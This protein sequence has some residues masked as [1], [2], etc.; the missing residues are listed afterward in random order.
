MRLRAAYLLASL[1]LVV[2]PTFSQ[3]QTASQSVLPRLV[4][5]GG[6][7]KDL[8]GNPLAG[9]VGITFALY[10][11]Q[12]GGGALWLET[13]NVI[14]D[15][16]GH[17][18]ALLGSTKPDGLPT[19]LFT[20]EQARW[21]GVQVSGQ[22]EQPRVLLLSVPYALK[23]AD[24]ETLGGKPASAYL[25]NP[26]PTESVPASAQ[27]NPAAAG[28][29][30]ITGKRAISASV[31]GSGTTNFIPRW[32]SS[33][34]LGN[35]VIFQSTTGNLGIGTTSPAATLDIRE[36][37]G[38]R[39]TT[40]NNGVAVFGDATV[41]SGT[42]KGVEGDSYSTSGTGVAGVAI[43]TTGFTQGVWG[44]SNSTT[45]VGMYAKAAATSGSTIGVEGISASSAGTA[46]VFNNTGGGKVLSGQTN[47]TVVFSVNGN[48]VAQ[49]GTQSASPTGML[50]ATS[51]S[52]S[53]AG[54]VATGFLPGLQLCHSAPMA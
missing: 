14:A 28:K 35:S 2:P 20:T 45:G 51:T 26:Q 8:N 21:V 13:Q 3:T 4:R 36:P 16:N 18:V 17:Y 43:A 52:I 10:S 39:A 40:S 24:A 25:L 9:V 47:G 53:Y 33:T 7:V 30:S 44:Q 34:G 27:S 6:T 54:L 32:T 11:E 37:T 50:N 22:A 41:A 5:F 42:G 15:S 1:L 23:A 19:E 38:V 31:A 46:G 29:A 49:V 12:T 48:G